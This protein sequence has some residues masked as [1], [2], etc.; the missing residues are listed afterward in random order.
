MSFVAM[1][2]VYMVVGDTVSKIK[3]AC[4]KLWSK[5]PG[6][7]CTKPQVDVKVKIDAKELEKA[8]SKKKTSKP[9]KKPKT[10]VIVEQSTKKRKPGRPRKNQK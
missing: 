4:Q 3:N 9:G 7:D 10:S 8:L 1:S 6:C 5:C 2:L